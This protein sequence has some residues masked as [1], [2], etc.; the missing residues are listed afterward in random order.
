MNLTS[1]EKMLEQNDSTDIALSLIDPFPGHPF[2][3]QED[4]EMEELVESI[5]EHGVLVPVILRRHGAG[6][7]QIVAGH[8]RCFASRKLQKETV[9]AVVKDL[10]EEEA[11]IWMVDSNIQRTNILPSEKAKAY[12]MKMDALS[13]QGCRTDLLPEDDEDDTASRQVVGRWKKE[14]AEQVGTENGDSGRQVQRYLRLNYL[15]PD[16]LN[17]VDQKSLAFLAGVELS[18]LT[19]ASQR[20]LSEC[21]MENAGKISLKQARHLKEQEQQ[22]KQEKQGTLTRDAIR[23]S[24]FQPGKNAAGV[25]EKNKA[26]DHSRVAGKDAYKK[27]FP[28]GYSAKERNRVICSLL[29]KWKKG[30][31]TV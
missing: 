9:P 7:Y 22:K 6:R 27:Y 13:K 3:V 10:S 26:S 11:V 20:A 14:S 15:I 17:R 18:Y 12:R 16:L 28:S 19:E 2:R 8:R 25:R 29:E 21:L 30:E 1:F 5:R 31:I 4:A 23:A 24:L